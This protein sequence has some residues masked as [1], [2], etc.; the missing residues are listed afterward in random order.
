MSWTSLEVAPDRSHH[1]TTEGSP[2]YV[3]RFDEVLKF[4]PPGL[5]PVLRGV[6]AWHIRPDGTPAYP[7]RFARTFGFYEGLAA[8]ES[9]DG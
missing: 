9:D 5:A 2:A 1:V 3:E 4:H 6:E 7:R 8:V